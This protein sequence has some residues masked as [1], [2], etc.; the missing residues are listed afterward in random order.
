MMDKKF[1]ENLK[2]LRRMKQYSQKNISKALGIAVSTYANWE[3]GRTEPSIA[4]IYKLINVFEVDANE[5][6]D[7]K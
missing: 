6:F 2:E 3:Q 4:D 1:C 5:L 7:I